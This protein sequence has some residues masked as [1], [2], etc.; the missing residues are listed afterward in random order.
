[1]PWRSRLVAGVPLKD[2]DFFTGFNSKLHTCLCCGLGDNNGECSTNLKR[3][4]YTH[5]G[6]SASANYN[7]LKRIK[8]GVSGSNTLQLPVEYKQSHIPAE[9]VCNVNRVCL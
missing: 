1:M 6:T 3:I 7:M 9:V 5:Y 4:F 8:M 2:L